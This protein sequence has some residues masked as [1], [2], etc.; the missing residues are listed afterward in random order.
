MILRSPDLG[1]YV[2]NVSLKAVLDVRPSAEGEERADDKE[3]FI[4][5][6]KEAGFSIENS[7]LGLPMT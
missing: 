7:R 3:L 5:A 4:A 6:L 1:S 2:F